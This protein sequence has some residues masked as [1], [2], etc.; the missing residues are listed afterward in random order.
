M[1]EANRNTALGAD[2][3]YHNTTGFDNVAT[4]SQSLFSNTTGSDNTANGTGALWENTTGEAN[5]A[6]GSRA[7]SANTTGSYRT[8]LGSDASG[9]GTNY[10]NTTALGYDAI[11]TG[12]NVVNIG[13]TSVAWIGGQV[14]WSTYSD[15]RI[16]NN[17]QEDVKGLDFILKLRPVTYNLDIDKQQEI[18][19]G[20]V[21]TNNWKGK[22]DIENIK[23]SGFIAQEVAQAAKDAGYNFSGVNEP[24]NKNETGEDLYTLRYAEFVVPLV[25]A[26]QEQ[27]EKIDKQQKQLIEYKDQ[28]REQQ[29]LIEQLLNRIEKLEKHID[30][31]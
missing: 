28:V 25:K 29:A 14:G 6:I 18:L 9:F 1:Y 24:G 13:N 3:L 11:P 2:A 5:T 26:L 30:N 23:F 20:K 27:E 31:H 15:A 4:G 10:D 19:Y 22:Y 16:K 8:A 21:D 7:L 12:D 17:V